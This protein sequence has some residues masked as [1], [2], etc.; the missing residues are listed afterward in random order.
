MEKLSVLIIETPDQCEG[1]PV[2]VYNPETQTIRC[3]KTGREG[4]ADTKGN[5][6]LKQECQLRPLPDREVCNEY[7]FESY[8][9]GLN[10]GWNS[11]RARITGEKY[12]PPEYKEG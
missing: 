10:V 3:S 5:E 8:T 1:C 9:N 7:N 4:S 2:C 6:Y 12:I 11:F